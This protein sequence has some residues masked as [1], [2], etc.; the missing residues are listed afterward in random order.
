MLL[1]SLLTPQDHTNFVNCVRYS[2]DGSRFVSVSS[3]KK[4]LVRGTTIASLASTS[5]FCCYLITL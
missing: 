2:P 5:A 3:D 1:L 4:A